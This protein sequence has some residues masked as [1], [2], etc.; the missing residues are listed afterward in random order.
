M[1]IIVKAG[2]FKENPSP[3]RPSDI[4]PITMGR[5]VRDK[6]PNRLPGKVGAKPAAKYLFGLCIWPLF[7]LSHTPPP[8]TERPFPQGLCRRSSPSKISFISAL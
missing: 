6:R 3:R 8:Y 2:E 1:V 7:R 4:E 5:K